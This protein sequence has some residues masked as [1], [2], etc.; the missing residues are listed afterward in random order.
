MKFQIKA[1][2]HNQR[3]LK[4]ENSLSKVKI[5]AL[6]E[7]SRLRACNYNEYDELSTLDIVLLNMFYVLSYPCRALLVVE[8]ELK[9]DEVKRL[10]AQAECIQKQAMT[11]EQMHHGRIR[12]S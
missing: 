2:E 3:F 9:Q 11:V 5:A 1:H 6:E 8:V 12:R 4:R 7:R 10:R